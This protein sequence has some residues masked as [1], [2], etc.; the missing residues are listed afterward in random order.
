MPHA[1]LVGALAG[2]VER[3]AI[4]L[5]GSVG[6]HAGDDA[7]SALHV[8]ALGAIAGRIYA[9]HAGLHGSIDYH[10][11]QALDAA[12]L[13]EVDIR[14]RTRAM[15]DE[16]GMQQLTIRQAYQLGSIDILQLASAYSRH[17]CTGEHPDA[18]RLA[19][20]LHHPAG[21]GRQHSRQDTIALF[22]DGKA[23]T[24]SGAITP[25][26]S[27]YLTQPRRDII[28]M[29][30]DNGNHVNK[31]LAVYDSSFGELVSNQQP[32]TFRDF[33]LSAPYMFLELGEKMGAISHIVSFWRYRFPAGG[34]KNIDADELTIIFQDFMGGFGERKQEDGP[35]FQ[36]PYII[37]A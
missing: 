33:L 15:N 31:A 22:D 5:V 16:V 20:T 27:A 24:A 25:E 1:A 29:V 23:H 28:Q 9:R 4:S 36:R 13:E 3:R 14:H 12:A 30:R 10:A 32:K 19:P 37:E 2:H 35:T 6:L 11:A 21:T 17:A 34:P 7:A 8:V 18:F 26:Q